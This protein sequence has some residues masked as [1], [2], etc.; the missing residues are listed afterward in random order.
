[1]HVQIDVFV[2]WGLPVLL[3]SACSG[4]TCASI[5]LYA[6]TYIYVY[7]CRYTN[8]HMHLH[9]VAVLAAG[10]CMLRFG[11]DII[12]THVLQVPSKP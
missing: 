12:R 4:K 11:S 3:D 6:C 9:H 7:I 10:A 5:G 1:M 2:P 8:I